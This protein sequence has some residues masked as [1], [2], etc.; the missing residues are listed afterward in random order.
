MSDIISPDVLTT[1]LL[2]FGLAA[3][4]A[5]ADWVIDR[6]QRGRDRHVAAE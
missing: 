3:F 6:L 4:I 5:V 1:L 2:A